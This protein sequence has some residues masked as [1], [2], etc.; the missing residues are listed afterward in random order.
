MCIDL[1]WGF[2]IAVAL[3]VGFAVGL[4]GFLRTGDLQK[5]LL[6]GVATF[7]VILIARAIYSQ[8]C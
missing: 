2:V 4:I 8:V 7:A 6:S 5:A 1:P 3:A